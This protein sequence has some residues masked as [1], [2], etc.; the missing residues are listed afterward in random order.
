[1]NKILLVSEIFPPQ[2]GGSGRW[3]WEVYSRLASADVIVAA[4]TY[5]GYES[6]D[7]THQLEIVRLPLAFSEWGL[8]SSGALHNYWRTLGQVT[9]L[10]RKSSVEEV[11]CGRCIPEGWVALLHRMRSGIPYVC[12]V[13]GEDVETAATSRELSWMVR[14]VLSSAKYLIANSHNTAEI[15]KR[16]WRLPGDRIRVVHPGVDTRKFVPKS[17]DDVVRRRLGW[18]RRPVVLTVGRLHER[19]GQD[20]MIRALEHVHQYV[21]NALYAVVGGGEDLVRLR[22]LSNKGGVSDSVRFYN[23]VDD[24]TMIEMYQQCDV[25]VL[26][27]RQVGR[28]IEGFGMVLLEAQACGKPVIAGMSGGTAETM[29][30]GKT[31]LVV[32]CDE[33]LTLAKAVCELLQREDMRL[34]FGHE[35]RKWVVDNFGWEIVTQKALAVFQN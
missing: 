34:R 30:Q 20:M 22:E 25:F 9:R 12:Y 6:F 23:E 32:S 14:R 27:N 28:D 11:H 7:E 17:R 3:F 33:P 16:R 31:G 24:P 4:G 8:S 29:I 26:P 10:A 18:N 19:K 13:H 2:H 35:A 5:P 1:M 21:P 15:L